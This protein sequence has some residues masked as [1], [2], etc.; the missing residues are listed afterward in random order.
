MEKFGSLEFVAE[1]GV[2]KH[3][4]VLWKLKCDCG[5]DTVA[6]A[7]SVRTGHTKSCGC[8]KRQ[9]NR[10]TH[11][12]RRSRL[13]T[14]WC[15]MK[16]RCDNLKHPSY[17]NY[18]GRGISYDPAWADFTVFAAAV[19]EPPSKLHTL[20]RVDNSGGY[21]MG[22]VRWAS[23]YIQ[24]RNTRQNVWVELDGRTKCLHDW[25]SE[26]GVS[27]GAVYRRIG[28]GEDIVSA[29]TRPKAERFKG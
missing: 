19:G 27:A 13:Y 18:G 17:R 26:F 3:G 29:L 20:D 8:G 9:G 7:S 25:C 12:Q 21:N 5:N 28:R 15:N 2:N 4:K 14:I 6:V 1:A 23:R 10:R 22:N 24:A 11:G 16:A